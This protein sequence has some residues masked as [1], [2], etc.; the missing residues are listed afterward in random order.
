MIESLSLL[1]AGDRLEDEVQLVGHGGSG[2]FFAARLN[3][4]KQSMTLTPRQDLS[5]DIRGAFNDAPALARPQG[6]ESQPLAISAREIR[7]GAAAIDEKL[8]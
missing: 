1:V 8:V 6:Y 7:S 4:P 5:Q 3:S 2:P